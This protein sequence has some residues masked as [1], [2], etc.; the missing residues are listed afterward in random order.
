MGALAEPRDPAIRPL[1]AD[2]EAHEPPEARGLPRDGVRMMVS[3][4]EDLPVHASFTQL[5]AFLRPG[6]VLVV[7]TS[8]TV[9]AALDAFLP[10][11]EPVVVHV[12]TQLPGGLWL[13]EVRRGSGGATAPFDLP[14]AGTI[15]LLAGGTAT[16]L[17]RFSDSRR[18]W[19]A[20]FDLGS[21][22]VDHL[23]RHGRPVRYRHVPDEWPIADYQTV[24]AAE[25]GSAEMP[26]AARPFT[27]DVVTHLVRSGVVVAPLALHTGVSSLEGHETPYPER[28]V[29]PATTAAI[30]NA[31]R[32]AGGRLVA[33]GTTVVRAIET[34]AD[35]QGRLHP[36]SGW[37][38]VVVSPDHPVRA[39]DALLTGWHE[40]EASHLWMLEAIAG[41]TALE[42]AYAAAFESGYL[43]HEF[44]DTHLLLPE[45]RC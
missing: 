28:Y 26:S 30:V 24:F 17:S 18:L 40:P 14:E 4:G 38:E 9:P 43:W 10:S 32:D 20:T 19:V 41:R 15:T 31:A 16:L 12:S 7:N 1:D 3:P 23:Q 22:V 29:V 13:V 33:V 8:A 36:G 6:D 11:G 39:V 2:H 5:P 34:V 42:Q 25:P 35:A 37:T 45:A 27:P 44:G 21:P